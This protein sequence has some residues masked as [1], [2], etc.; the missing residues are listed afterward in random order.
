MGGI[1]DDLQVIFCG[2]RLYLIHLTA[3]T[4]IVNGNYDLS[5]IRNGILNQILVD[6]HC[7][8]SDVNKDYLG[9]P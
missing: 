7:V 9:T 1:L 3:D 4:G 2:D 8:R 5:L 6:I